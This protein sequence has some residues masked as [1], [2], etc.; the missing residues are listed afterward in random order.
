MTKY[1]LPFGKNGWG[2]ERTPD[3]SGKTVVITGGNSGIGLEAAKVLVS[4]NA[5]VTIFCR[6]EEK[7]KDAVAQ[8]NEHATPAASI[9]YVLMDLASLESVR[10]AANTYLKT[11]ETLD[12]LLNNAGLMMIP[13]RTL[14][15]DGFETQFGVNHL[16]HFLFAQMLYPL[17]EKAKGRII[18]VSSIAHRW[19]LERIKFEDLN[20][21]EGYSSTVS[22][23]QSKLA[24]M[25]FIHE[26]Q[27][28]LKAA[29]SAVDAYVVHP[30]YADTNLQRTGPGG[31]E[32]WLMVVFGR[33]LSH[34]PSHGAK[35]L[36]LA[37][38]DPEAKP[39]TFYGPVKRGGLGGPVGETPIAPWGRDMDAAAKLWQVSEELTGAKWDI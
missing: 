34:P 32:K 33:F 36:V 18:A 29:G 16:G 8:I 14:T 2:Y 37:A 30:G 17:V 13:T 11:H 26:L 27:H 4:K 19:G 31:I 23:G 35:S 24:N 1:K 7:A 21:D 22:Y 38:A 15:K 9:D 10:A 3:M 39:V 20:F 12:V 25:L 6:N 5:H 28:R